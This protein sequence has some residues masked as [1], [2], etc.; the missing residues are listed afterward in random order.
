MPWAFQ[1]R[2]TCATLV[3]GTAWYDATVGSNPLSAVLQRQVVNGNA[4]DGE[5]PD[6][7]APDGEA[8]DGEAPDGEAT[9]GETALM[10]LSTA[11]A[12]VAFGTALASGVRAA[13][14]DDRA[15][16]TWSPLLLAAAVVRVAGAGAVKGPRTLALLR[17][18]DAVSV[19]RAA[20]CALFVETASRATM[21]VMY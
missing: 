12:L 6:G 3:F 14:L 16:A 17:A 8:T 9:D 1:A 11:A 4:T 13:F 10:A 19:S 7:E 2:P 20:E 18:A 15:S 21:P 5:A